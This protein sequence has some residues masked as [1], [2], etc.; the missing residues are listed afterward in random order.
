MCI[1]SDRKPGPHDGK[2]KKST[3]QWWSPSKV[4]FFHL[5]QTEIKC[6]WFDFVFDDIWDQRLIILTPKAEGFIENYI[7]M[8]LE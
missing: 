3:E 5:N 8:F 4:V 6:N 2:H 1:D 7:K